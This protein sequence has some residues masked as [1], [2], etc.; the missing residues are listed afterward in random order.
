MGK[1]NRKKNQAEKVAAKAKAAAD[2]TAGMSNLNISNQNDQAQD[3]PTEGPTASTADQITA[4]QETT[5]SSAHPTAAG[6]DPP[7]STQGD[8]VAVPNSGTQDTAT[9]ALAPPATTNPHAR[10]TPVTASKDAIDAMNKYADPVD[11]G[12]SLAVT[13]NFLPITKTPL[14]FHEYLVKYSMRK[15]VADKDGVRAPREVRRRDEKVEVLKSL[16]AGFANV[17]FAFSVECDKIWSLAPIPGQHRDTGA[18]LAI[19][20]SD[21]PYTRRDNIAETLDWINLTLHETWTFN[22][23]LTSAHIYSLTPPRQQL[24][25]MTMAFASNFARLQT[26]IAMVGPSRFFTMDSEKFRLNE[27]VFAKTGYSMSMRAL[28]A[29]VGAVVKPTA[30]CFLYGGP[31]RTVLSLIRQILKSG[32]TKDLLDRMLRGLRVQINF[33]RG[34][35]TVQTNGKPQNLDARQH[36]LK[37]IAKVGLLATKQFIG[38]SEAETVQGHMAKK[39]E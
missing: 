34:H 8:T 27:A 37:T 17:P 2:A 3:T 24:L 15:E 32:G 9:T 16:Q 12:E 36:Q 26:S 29:G 31:E 4:S 28:K 6:Q 1:N 23:P 5:A 22:I 38:D 20:F 14:I 33:K 35:G 7:A 25:D 21:V 19:R 39:C 30:T 18:G 10:A 11:E 13:S